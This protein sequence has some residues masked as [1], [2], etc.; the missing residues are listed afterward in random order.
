LGWNIYH[1]QR[2]GPDGFVESE[3]ELTMTHKAY[4]LRNAFILLLLYILGAKTLSSE[5]LTLTEKTLQTI[6]ECMTHLPAPWPEAWQNEYVDTGEGPFSGNACKL[7]ESIE[8]FSKLY[9]I[10]ENIKEPIDSVLATFLALSFCDISTSQDHNMLCEQVQKLSIGV[11]TQIN[12]MLRGRNLNALITQKDMNDIFLRYEQT[13]REYV[14]DPL[15]P[16]LKFPLSKNEEIILANKLKLRCARLESVFE[17]TSLMVKY[18]G[19]SSQ[20]KHKTM[21]VIARAALAIMP[22]AVFLRKPPFPGIT[23]QY[24]IG[25][26]FTVVINSQFYKDRPKERFIAMK[27]FHIGNYLSETVKR[28]RRLMYETGTTGKSLETW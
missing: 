27:Y 23:C 22:E 15:W 5:S 17:E 10:V 13:F 12:T 26:G 9:F 2:A 25:H 21:S 28:E 7:T 8:R 20:L 16:T 6:Q 18:G 19:H 11:Q 4:A 3:R 14:D 24:R 1:N